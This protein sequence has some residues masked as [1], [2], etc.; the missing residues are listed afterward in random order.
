MLLLSGAGLV[1]TTAGLDERLVVE[2]IG[3]M[4]RPLRHTPGTESPRRDRC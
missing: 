4:L 3:Q 1:E 2:M